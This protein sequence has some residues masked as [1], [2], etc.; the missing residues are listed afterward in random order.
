MQLHGTLLVT[1]ANCP[2]LTST[3][4]SIGQLCRGTGVPCP[5]CPLIQGHIWATLSQ[6]RPCTPLFATSSQCPGAHNTTH[7]PDPVTASGVLWCWCLKHRVV[8]VREKEGRCVPCSFSASP[9]YC[10][11]SFTCGFSS[12]MCHA[13]RVTFPCQSGRHCP[14]NDPEAGRFCD[15][16][17][18]DRLLWVVDRPMVKGS[19]FFP[20]NRSLVVPPLPCQPML[21]FPHNTLPQA[22][23]D[24]HRTVSS[25]GSLRRRHVPGLFASTRQ[26]VR[27]QDCVFEH[28]KIIP[29][30][31]RCPPYSLHRTLRVSTLSFFADL[32][33]QA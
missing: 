19:L 28:I 23:E 18:R 22:T 24:F 1:L 10:R 33:S 14:N 16:A 26:N 4:D 2:L 11:I 8:V 3:R 29:S 17:N 6:A 21:L 9:G 27:L 5:L 13:V 30:T 7:T 31:K 25:Q 15:S 12:L 20:F 32:C